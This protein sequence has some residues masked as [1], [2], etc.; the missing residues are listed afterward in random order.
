[1]SQELATI[2]EKIA[3]LE[4]Q[5]LKTLN[6]Q[7]VRRE[8]SFAKQLVAGSTQ[9]QKCTVPSVLTAIYNICNIGLSLNPA[10]KEAYI[11]PRYNSQINGTEASLQPSYVGLIK[12]LTDAGTV[13]SIV[14]NV[15]HEG[16]DFF[17]DAASSE[18]KHRL[19]LVKANKGQKI[20]AYALAT[21]SDGRPQV[22][23]MEVDEIN[24]IRACSESYKNEKT[25]AYSPWEKH[26]D[27][28]ACKTVI[29][30]LYKY[31][32][33]SGGSKQSIIDE[34]ID[35]DDAQYPASLTQISYIESLLR[36][37]NITAE[38]ERRIY[39]EVN[40]Y[41]KAE[42]ETCIEYLKENQIETN[43]AK[44]FVERAKN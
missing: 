16:D 27:E 37:A 40:S 22:K 17:I 30:R 13:K 23:W 32:P 8:L 12:L 31:L 11:V 43:P 20:G 29:R 41:S 33:R 15:V 42:A 21:L 19:C 1:M 25:R 44:Q 9:L 4:P 35:M 6:E 34:A 18:V 5:M 39:G 28:M 2:S 10:A 26:W 3:S 14:A 36:T 24:E 7:T 38:T